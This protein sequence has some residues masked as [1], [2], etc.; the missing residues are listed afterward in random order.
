MMSRLNLEVGQNIR[1]FRELHEMKMETLARALSITKG[2]LSRI[3]NGI[4]DIS[5]SRIEQIAA[6][7][8]IPVSRLLEPRGVLKSELINCNFE[9][10]CQKKDDPIN[11]V[12]LEKIN[13]LYQLME[14]WVS[15]K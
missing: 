13:T 9:H 3:E 12:I 6:Y 15:M 4:T 1:R 10:I 5:L 7:L 14:K 8:D 2:S 11:Q